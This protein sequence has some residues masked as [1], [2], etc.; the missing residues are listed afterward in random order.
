MA[1][2]ST[3]RDIT[4]QEEVKTTSR[5]RIG[6]E[7]NPEEAIA[8]LQKRLSKI[9]ASPEQIKKATYA[10]KYLFCQEFLSLARSHYDEIRPKGYQKHCDEL[11]R[12]TALIEKLGTEM[13][14]PRE[15][16]RKTLAPFSLQS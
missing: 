1:K 4:L 13:S 11:K 3:V 14:V 6:E 15:T 10:I 8:S 2:E 7:P 16:I 5:F 9:K 12:I